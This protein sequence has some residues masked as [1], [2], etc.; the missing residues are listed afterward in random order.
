VFFLDAADKDDAN[1][2]EHPIANAG[3]P[4][5]GKAN[6]TITFDGSASVD[7]DGSIENYTWDFG[8]GSIRSTS[9]T[10]ITHV[11]TK[12]E[13]YTV[14]LT[15][16]DNNGSANSATTFALITEDDHD[17]DEYHHIVFIEEATATNCKNCPPI[18][19]ILEELF[20]SGEYRF[21]YVAM[22]NDT[23]ENAEN[24]LI[25]DYNLWALPTVY[26]DGGYE[27]V[28][29]GNVEKSEFIQAIQAAESRATP[30]IQ[31]MVTAEYDNTTDEMEVEVLVENHE[32][33]PYS[34]RL[35]VYLTEIISRWNEYSG[36]KY[37][38]GFLDFIINRDITVAAAS[39][40]TFSN[41]WDVT[42]L[43]VGNLMLFAVV[44]NSEPVVKYSKPPDEHPFDAYYADATNAT[45][46][47]EGGDLPPEVGITFPQPGKI[48]RRGRPFFEAIFG[49]L[50]L[51]NAILLGPTTIIIYAKDDTGVERVELQIQGPFRT[52]NATFYEEPYEWTWRKLAIGGKYTITVTAYDTAGQNSTATLEVRAFMRPFL[53]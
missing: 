2:N 34:G 53:F 5:Y 22:V 10:S 36:K 52:F 13:N 50:T 47:V 15:V 40:V 43:S 31:V 16:T 33:E 20:N 4:Y 49:N 26:I 18:G 21:Y 27:V 32:N 45:R 28:I 9:E 41:T 14:V 11:Y 35:R 44:F 42:D 1:K 17:G 7:P 29:G 38:Y 23:N 24:R 25:N 6:Q 12:A 37:H 30:K 48:Y 51:R 3:G 46:V 8:D 39:E 19:E